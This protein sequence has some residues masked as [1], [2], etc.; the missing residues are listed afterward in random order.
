MTSSISGCSSG[1][2]PLM[3]M[4]DVPIFANKSSRRFISSSGTGI[5]TSSNS[6]QYV[7]A[8]LH[9][10]IGMICTRMGCLVES[11]A[12]TIMRNSRTRVCAKRAAR[13]TRKAALADTAGLAPEVLVC[14]PKE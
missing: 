4:I 9:L 1:S 11:S 2:P 6:L 5:D 10:R 14:G 3:V 7:H 8:R 13:R 12:F